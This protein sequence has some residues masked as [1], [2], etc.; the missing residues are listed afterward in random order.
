MEMSLTKGKTSV[1]YHCSDYFNAYEDFWR[2][3][4]M[5][6]TVLITGT[7]SGIGAAFCDLMAREKYNLIL[8]ARDAKALS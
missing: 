3:H 2:K 8:V 7:T 1:S 6:R 5:N 4:Y